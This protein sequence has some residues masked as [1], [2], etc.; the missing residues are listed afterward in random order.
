MPSRPK[1]FCRGQ[2]EAIKVEMR[3][4]D[5]FKKTE[6]E[7]SSFSPYATGSG[8]LLLI[9]YVA[10]SAGTPSPTAIIA[11]RYAKSPC[12]KSQIRLATHRPQEVLRYPKAQQGTLRFRS[13][14]GCNP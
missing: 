8:L 7:V 10:M 3:I 2:E 14:K 9:S 5:C 1:I 4:I 6:S 12:E 11:S 13:M